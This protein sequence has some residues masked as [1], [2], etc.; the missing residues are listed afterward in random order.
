MIQLAREGEKLG[1]CTKMPAGLLRSP[2][3][4][5]NA[6]GVLAGLNRVSETSTA[7]WGKGVFPNK[8]VLWL[9]PNGLA[10]GYSK[11]RGIDSRL[12]DER[13]P[14][15]DEERELFVARSY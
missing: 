15:N 12:Q 6:S 1:C 11:T 10:V 2:R 13:N 5:I 3:Q 7:H 14:F 8:S 9:H 4:S